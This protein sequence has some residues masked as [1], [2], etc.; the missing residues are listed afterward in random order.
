MET[1]QNTKVVSAVVVIIIILFAGY[2]L[3]SKY[4]RSPEEPG[5]LEG[6]EQEPVSVVVEN[7]QKVDGVLPAPSGFPTDIPTETGAVLESVT[8]SYPGQGAKQLSLSYRSSKTVTQKYTEYKNY[9][10]ASGY[11]IKEGAANS[12]V[13][14]IFGTKQESNLS[15]AIS[16]SEGKTLV[17]LSY[18]L[19]SI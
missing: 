19:K 2:F 11:Q 17:Q 5:N 12:P 1:E 9:M 4:D 6:T 15:V 10:T 3:M 18:L 16:S 13:R 8:T 14:A 7:T